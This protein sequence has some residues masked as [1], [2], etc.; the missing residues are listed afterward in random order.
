M[1]FLLYSNECLITYNHFQFFVLIKFTIQH[2]SNFGL[3]YCC[4]SKLK[5]S[6]RIF[7]DKSLFFHDSPN[8]AF[9]LMHRPGIARV[10]SNKIVLDGTT[11]EEVKNYHRDTL[12]LAVKEA[13]KKYNDYMLM[14]EREETNRIQKEQQHY[15]NVLKHANDIEFD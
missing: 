10:V 14:K 7:G 11:I 1:P 13:N 3:I 9:T 4:I 8:T 2:I 6:N 12:I 15:S 5:L